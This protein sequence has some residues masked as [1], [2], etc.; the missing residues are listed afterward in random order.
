MT[1]T[2]LIDILNLMPKLG[3]R[4]ALRYNNGYRTFVFTYNQLYQKIADCQHALR[5]NG[6]QPGDGLVLWGENCWQWVTVF[7]AAVA[8]GLEIIPIDARFSA[9][10]VNNIS[11]QTAPKFLVHGATVQAEKTHL[12]GLSFQEISYFSEGRDLSF[13]KVSPEDVLEIVY[14]SGTT[15]EPK[16]VVHRHKNI[17]ANL[18]PI[19]REINKYK[20]LLRPFQPLR[21]M[22]LLPLS[23]MFGQALG[24]FIPILLGGSSVMVKDLSVKTITQSIRREGVTSL[25]AVPRILGQIEDYLE[26]SFSIKS[27]KIKPGLLRRLW[28]YRD[29]HSYL[30]WKFWVVV[31]G[32]AQLS[33]DTEKW[34]SELGFC[35]VQ[36]Y[37]LTE[38]SPIISLNHP[39]KIKQGSLGKALEGQ[40]VRISND[41]EIMVRGESVV[42]EYYKKDKKEETTKSSEWLRTGDIGWMDSEGR[43]YFKGRKKDVIVLSDG[44]N[45]YPE[46]V[47]EEINK[48]PEVWDSA[49]VG[50]QKN[51]DLVV[52][53][54]IIP[55]KE[56]SQPE[57]I[58][59]RVN[60]N[61]EP[62]QRIKDWTIWSEEDFPRTPSTGKV[63][64]RL[65]ADRISNQEKEEAV[66]WPK[67]PE[68][69]K[70]EA[71]L[72]RLTGLEEDKIKDQL[73][74]SEDL[75]ISSLDMVELMASLEE[76]FSVSL[77]EAA[78][79]QL[80][81][82]GELR[83]FL[84][85]NREPKEVWTKKYD[86]KEISE[87][88]RPEKPSSIR[89]YSRPS[90]SFPRWSR[91]KIIT[92]ARFLFQEGFLIPAFKIYMRFNV[93]GREQLRDWDPP[94]IFAAN[95]SSHLDS[96]AVLAALNPYWR[97]RLAPAM[98][99]EFF[100]SHFS[101]KEKTPWK[102]RIT[103]A[104]EYYLAC[105]LFNGYPLPQR[106]GALR[107]SI[108]YT[109]ELISNNYC[110]LVFP[111]GIMTP[112]GTVQPFQPGVG[113]MAIQFQV[114]VVPVYIHG[115]FELFPH[116]SKWPKPGR[117]EVTL[118]QAIEACPDDDYRSFAKRLEENVR[119]I[120]QGQ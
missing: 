59:W 10:F 61:L 13:T 72:S 85:Q 69:K 109:G 84:D 48:Q 118:G 40:E 98:L 67:Q 41:G 23:H 115:L 94:L 64:R 49:V 42:H 103:S 106:V 35:V 55:E 73:R 93:Y 66:P 91:S 68:K 12:D 76:E 9:N 71:V 27:R 6:L 4:E 58:I 87:P 78:F 39:F 62:H 20:K 52:Q 8:Y 104:L 105:A 80:T 38:A 57:K 46:D 22:N 15:G 30:G 99:L 47:E 111:E 36:G 3:Q 11:A 102:K 43:L 120:S 119:R 77:D 54:A 34:W 75:G 21:V 28:A 25:V 29:I 51:K 83:S 19:S 16:G 82:V 63:I 81:T 108:Q 45:V 112:D 50:I 95:H 56:I 7:W 2:T 92:W 110:P 53:A 101:A 65:V 79:G 1:L 24:L 17:C 86:Q 32:G 44:S 37:G 114:P 26:R 90:F 97:K 74:L 31:V 100:Q 5:K 113:L 96:T 70:L 14:T 18:R 60:Q 116:T 89:D 88:L 33:L 107:E 117:V